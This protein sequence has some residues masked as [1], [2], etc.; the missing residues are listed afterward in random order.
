MLYL[1][2]NKANHLHV[3]LYCTYHL[4]QT[5]WLRRAEKNKEKGS[6][7]REKSANNSHNVT[8]SYTNSAQIRD[9]SK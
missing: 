1:L 8:H 7:K 6:F 2:C 3:F 4:L 9:C 5:V